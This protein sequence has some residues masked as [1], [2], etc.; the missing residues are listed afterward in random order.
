M[1]KELFLKNF[2]LKTYKV[3][4]KTVGLDRK[5][6]MANYWSVFKG[7]LDPKF[8]FTFAQID[9]KFYLGVVRSY[10][11]ATRYFIKGFLVNLKRRA[12]RRRISSRTILKAYYRAYKV[13]LFID[14][15]ANMYEN[16]LKKPDYY[17]KGYHTVVRMSFLRYIAVFCM[18][19]FVLSN[20]IYANRVL[21]IV[22]HSSFFRL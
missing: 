19:I 15:L 14:H 2:N 11:K 21:R 9:N 17:Y 10:I 12:K 6:L 20:K 4:K 8:S 13:R 18:K 5:L 22:D 3:F 1:I 7:F 16:P